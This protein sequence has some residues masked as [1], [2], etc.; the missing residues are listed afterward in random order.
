VELKEKVHTIVSMKFRW[1]VNQI[2]EKEIEV[3]IPVGNGP[4]LINP[5]AIDSLQLSTRE[6]VDAEAAALRELVVLK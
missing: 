3:K 6:V 5:A 2:A 4:P 1:P